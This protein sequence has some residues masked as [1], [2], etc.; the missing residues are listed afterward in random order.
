MQVDSLRGMSDRQVLDDLQFLG[1][2]DSI[3]SELNRQ[4]ATT[5]LLP[6]VSL[7]EGAVS[8]RMVSP[9]E[10]VDPTRI[11]FEVADTRQMWLTF[12]Q[13]VWGPPTATT[14]K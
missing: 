8:K 1:I 13:C 11:L 4:T 5:N 9:G 10:I 6:V 3:R 14:P 2:P 7:I 12:A